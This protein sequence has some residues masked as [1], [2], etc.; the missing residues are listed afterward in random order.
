MQPEQPGHRFWS[1][2]FTPGQKYK[3]PRLSK[4]PPIY[5]YSTSAACV[6][7]NT[8]FFRALV[9]CIKK[10]W[11]RI[12]L[13]PYTRTVPMGSN[14][15]NSGGGDKGPGGGGDSGGGEKGACRFFQ[16]PRSPLDQPIWFLSNQPRTKMAASAAAATARRC[17]PS[18]A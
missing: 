4:T 8:R 9:P 7:C 10:L 2:P 1:W 16:S 15:G 17:R 14:G 12:F 18:H 11:T 3:W 5:A 13:I 6:Y